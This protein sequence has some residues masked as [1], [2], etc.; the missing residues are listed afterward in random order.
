MAALRRGAI[1]SRSYSLI[2][3]GGCIGGAAELLFYAGRRWKAGGIGAALVFGL[4][5][6]ALL[7]LAIYFFRLALR[8]HAESKR[9]ALLPPDQPPDFSPLQDGSQVVRNLE[10]MRTED[11]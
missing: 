4:L 11:K 3:L 6:A 8:F 10:N 7:A 1:R 5:A 9:S 2:A